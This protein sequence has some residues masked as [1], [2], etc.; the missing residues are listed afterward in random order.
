MKTDGGRG[1]CAAVCNAGMHNP[2]SG[3]TIFESPASASH[4]NSVHL[5]LYHS[6]SHCIT[7]QITAS[8]CISLQL[9]TSSASHSCASPSSAPGRD[10][11]LWHPW[12]GCTGCRRA[13]VD[14]VAFV[15]CSSGHLMEVKGL[16]FINIEA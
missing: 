2:K 3:C 6:A 4:C 7:V 16:F 8:N 13:G 5:I 10:K 15:L 11:Q 1:G 9:S 12:P 14:E